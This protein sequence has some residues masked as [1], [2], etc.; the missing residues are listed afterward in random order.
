V[1][2]FFE[3][4]PGKVLAGLNRRIVPEHACVALTDPQLIEQTLRG[5]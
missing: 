2:Q 5:G 4:G 3:C 1:D